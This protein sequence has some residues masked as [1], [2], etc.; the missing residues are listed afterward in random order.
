MVIDYVNFS[1]R[2]KEKQYE[3]IVLLE[4][5]EPF[6]V[7]K[8]TKMIQETFFAT[9]A[10]KDFDYQLFYGNEVTINQIID[11]SKQF[12]MMGAKRLVVV[13]G[14]QVLEKKIADLLS[15]VK[16]PQKQ[17]V[18]VLAFTEGK[19][20]DGKL[21]VYKEIVK[22]GL[23]FRSDK[24]YD[25]KLA[26][27]VMNL[28]KE[29][30]LTISSR[31]IDLLIAQIGNNLSRINKELDKLENVVPN[32]QP[33]D[34]KIIET[35]IGINREYNMFELARA[36]LARDTAKAF[37]IT[38][39]FIENPGKYTPVVP[40]VNIFNVFYKLL[41][42]YYLP[43]RLSAGGQEQNEILK[44]LGVFWTDYSIYKAAINYYPLP[45]IVT[46][47]HHIRHYSMLSKGA[48]GWQGNEIDLVREL[49]WKILTI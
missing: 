9:E 21:A 15:Y 40:F 42:Y 36:I 20:M 13:R 5:E 35:Y 1:K 46:I 26:P 31:E 2:I 38:D 25:N 30:K 3:P 22:N 44:K 43:E 17:T 24:I 48:N 23:V 49:T 47:L 19:K 12:P 29:K 33:I 28:A 16:N 7:D 41:Q 27:H 10:E 4:G 32:G 37:A 34:S 14:A 8:L 39:Y 45:K 11:I 18:L 6:Y